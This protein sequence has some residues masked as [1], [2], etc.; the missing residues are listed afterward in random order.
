MKYEKIES[1]DVK[2]IRFL[3]DISEV[4]S[5]KEKKFPDKVVRYGLFGLKKKVI[6]GHLGF[7]DDESFSEVTF[8]HIRDSIFGVRMVHGDFTFTTNLRIVEKMP[9]KKLFE[10]P[11]IQLVYNSGGTHTY[12]YSQFDTEE[13]EM[14]E[15]NI[16]R[17]KDILSGAKSEV[18]IEI[19]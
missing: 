14:Y 4:T 2:E 6:N 15:R 16:Q 18:W 9:D 3:Y 19:L 7:W 10:V 5:I 17:L 1:K 8:A 12:T 11:K 13:M